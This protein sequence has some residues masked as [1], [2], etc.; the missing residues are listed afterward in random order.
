MTCREYQ[1]LIMTTR[2]GDRDADTERLI[3]RHE[4]SCA[5]CLA[6]RQQVEQMLALLH[7]HAPEQPAP[8]GFA[9]T[10]AS[11]AINRPSSH[12]LSWLDRLFG[13]ARPL[14]PVISFQKAA[15]FAGIVLMMGSAG[16]WMMQKNTPDLQPTNLIAQTTVTQ[17]TTTTANAGDYME[18]MLEQ[19]RGSQSLQPLPGSDSMRLSSY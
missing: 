19:H 16:V 14:R 5:S 18:V 11:R 2:P 8:S 6:E 12:G 1:K 15:A 17:S 13:V 4:Q 7:K 10:V 9:A 3:A